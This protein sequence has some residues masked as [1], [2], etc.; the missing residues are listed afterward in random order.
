MANETAAAVVL[1]QF[2]NDQISVAAWISIILVVIWILNFA[3]VRFYGEAEFILASI[4]IL[5]ILGLLILTIVIDLGGAPTHDRLGFRYWKSPYQAMKSYISSGSTGR[6]LGLFHVLI[7]AAF[8]FGGVEQVAVA[9]GETAN[10]TKAIPKAIRNVFYRIVFFY[11]LGAL[12]VGLL[13]PSNSDSLLHGTGAAKSP[14]VI[15][16]TNAGISV[17]PS[18]I[19]A[20]IITSASSSANANIYTGSRYL[21]ALAQ[22]KQAPQIF[23]RTTKHGVPF[24]AVGITGI[25]GLLA[26]T[27]VSSG[28]A[29]VFG[30]FSSIV[31]TAYLITWTAISFSYTRFRKAL[32]A[33]GISRNELDFK[34]I[35]QPYTAWFAVVF[36]GMVIF[37]NGFPVFTH[38]HWSAQDF[39]SAYIG[40]P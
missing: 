25:V 14:W 1:V 11:V 24:L 10:P 2:W 5:A 12:A 38:G 34:A 9:A 30:W 28:A 7:N 31:A 4:K 23:L 20:V 21:Y 19:N 33:Q 22:Q 17:L 15:G 26:Y 40:I 27:T 3:P 29:N 6:F 36:F 39:V 32:L 16:I 8:A 18:I 13:V 37:F 35:G